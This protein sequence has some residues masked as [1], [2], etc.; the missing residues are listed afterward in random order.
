MRDKSLDEEKRRR[1]EKLEEFK[2]EAMKELTKNGQKEHKIP[3]VHRARFMAIKQLKLEEEANQNQE[4][5]QINV[6]D[7]EI[8]LN[9]VRS[10]MVHERRNQYCVEYD[11]MIK[12]LRRYFKEKKPSKLQINRT[13]DLWADKW[14][15][16][17]PKCTKKLEK[18]LEKMVEL[19]KNENGA[20]FEI[21]TVIGTKYF[22][23]LQ[24]QLLKNFDQLKNL[25]FKLTGG[26][27]EQN[28]LILQ[29]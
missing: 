27:D 26:V 9:L 6:K 22:K 4:K 3:V 10:F 23:A 28:L 7:M 19:I 18:S 11:Q 2:K 17:I 24:P 25:F 14:D 8:C 13:Y 1:K 21:R 29:P 16:F 12:F 15:I 20:V 5:N